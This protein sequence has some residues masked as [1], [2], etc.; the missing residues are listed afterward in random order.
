MRTITYIDVKNEITKS[1]TELEVFENKGIIEVD[2]VIIRL[3]I[4]LKQLDQ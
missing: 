4:L 3:K 2:N 1:I